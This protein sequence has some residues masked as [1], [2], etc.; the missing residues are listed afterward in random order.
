MLSSEYCHCAGRYDAVSKIF[1][2]ETASGDMIAN[3]HYAYVMKYPGPV[4]PQ[5]IPIQLKPPTVTPEYPSFQGL[6]QH[7]FFATPLLIGR[8]KLISKSRLLKD[9]D[10]I[11]ATK[12]FS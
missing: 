6:D 1:Y 3:I 8:I 4:K 7:R 2:P 9:I 12:G 5:E 10:I 11:A